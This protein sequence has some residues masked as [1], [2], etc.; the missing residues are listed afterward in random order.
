[1][2]LLADKVDNVKCKNAIM[3]EMHNV[4]YMQR[5]NVEDGGPSDAVV[6]VIY[7][8]IPSPRPGF[9]EGNCMEEFLV[10]TWAGCA[11]QTMDQIWVRTPQGLELKGPCSMQQLLDSIAGYNQVFPNEFL[12]DLLEE[13]G[14]MAFDLEEVGKIAFELE[15]DPDRMTV[16]NFME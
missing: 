8:S 5:D 14:K 13:V 1:M 15:Q 12:D 11:K 2:Y 9:H 7:Q 6:K 16:E 3:A 4:W 10:R